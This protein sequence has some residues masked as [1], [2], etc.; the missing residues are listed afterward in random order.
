MT[1][2]DLIDQL[3]TVNVVCNKDLRPQLGNTTLDQIARLLFEHGVLIGDRNQLLVAETLGI[4]N[5]CEVGIAGLAEFTDNKR[6]IQLQK[7]NQ[8]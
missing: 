1:R 8:Y 7:H 5:V 4:R 6:F 3:A 2:A